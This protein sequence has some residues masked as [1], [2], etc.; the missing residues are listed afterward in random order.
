MNARSKAIESFVVEL[1]QEVTSL[2]NV[3]SKHLLDPDVNKFLTF[4]P[5]VTK[6]NLI[7]PV[8]SMDEFYAFNTR[9]GT[10]DELKHDL[11]S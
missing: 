4:N 10:N 3:L 1:Q 8:S 5:I 11:V 9:I 7:L 2:K 6:Y